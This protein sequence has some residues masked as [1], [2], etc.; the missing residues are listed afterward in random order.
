M[1]D[2]TG[3]AAYLSS[4][5]QGYRAGLLQQAQVKAAQMQNQ[6]QE[7]IRNLSLDSILGQSQAM[8]P[9]TQTIMAMSGQGGGGQQQQQA[10]LLS[11]SMVA[12]GGGTAQQQPNPGAPMMRGASGLQVAPGAGG[13]TMPSAT[14]P[15]QQ[16]SQGGG[17]PMPAQAM[18][19]SSPM[20]Q[21]PQGQGMGN[22]VGG[23]SLTGIMQKLKS[24]PR[25]K[26][27]PDIQLLGAASKLQ[28]AMNPDS[29]LLL[30]LLTQ[31]QKASTDQQRFDLEKRGQDLTHQD[32]QE[33]Q[34]GREADTQ[35]RLAMQGQVNDIKQQMQ[36]NAM[37]SPDDAK[38]LAQQRL[39]GD[40]SALS[41]LGFGNTGATNRRLVMQSMRDVLQQK[42]GKEAD[43]TFVAQATAAY[44]GDQAAIR[45]IAQKSA[46]ID[47]AANEMQ[48][49][50][51]QVLQ[52]S[53]AIPRSQFPTFNSM[54]Q[55]IEKGAGSPEIVRFIDAINAYKNAYAQV[56]SRGG[57]SSVDARLRSDEVINKA[58]SQGQIQA[59]IDQLG[60]EAKQAISATHE[61]LSDI[62]GQIG[63]VPGA[64]GG[65]SGSLAPAATGG[66]DGWKIEPVQ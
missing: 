37:L 15:M 17:S 8:D 2:L 33:A 20:P 41:G 1:A 64:S 52:T 21:M 44:G 42:F 39:A 27:I 9:T 40:K 62:T 5:P 3:L 50:A 46:M 61:T 34:R 36:Q 12:Q 29:K 31:Q 63:T 16:G 10:L 23:L 18:P 55:A 45:S 56:V 26:G 47:N 65:S 43:G 53:A 24:D 54:Q 58:W 30:Q 51:P 4:V 13:Q 66:N 32:R 7:D 57:A 35:A 28:S 14:P 38:F 60:L 11:P 6:D 48:K 22:G 59:A 25:N 19:Q 49:F